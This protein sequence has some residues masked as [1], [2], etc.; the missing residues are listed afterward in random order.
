MVIPMILLAAMGIGALIGGLAGA[1]VYGAKVATSKSVSWSW[2]AA[3]AH[4]LGG[5]VGGGLFPAVL[6]GLATVGVPTAA[7]YVV[8]GGVAWGGIWSLAQ[9]A[10][11]WAFGLEKGL[12]GPGKYLVATGVGMLATALLLPV[13]SRAIGPGLRLAPHSGTVEAFVRPTG[14][15]VAANLLKSEAEFLAYGAMSESANVVLNRVVTRT[16]ARGLNGVSHATG[17]GASRGGVEA[18]EAT[19]EGQGG[20]QE[21][22]AVEP[23]AMEPDAVESNGAEGASGDEQVAL[24]PFGAWAQRVHTEA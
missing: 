7:A 10:A 23:D 3:A 22:D 4:A 20:S 18:L 17:A 13:A 14:R 6:A 9:D 2:K 15:H 16:A 12:G 19:R 1:A 11:S 24:G 8:A 21:P 5:V